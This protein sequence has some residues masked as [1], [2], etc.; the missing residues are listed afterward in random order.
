MKTLS[1]KLGKSNVCLMTCQCACDKT[2]YN[3]YGSMLSITS[4]ILKTNVKSG[5]EMTK[6]MR[7][8]LVLLFHT[9][10]LSLLHCNDRQF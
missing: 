7:K 4:Q 8:K 1:L 10:F 2:E 9:V 6:V 3:Y 5:S